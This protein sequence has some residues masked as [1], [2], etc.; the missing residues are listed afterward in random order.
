MS[1]I[2]PPLRRGFP[3]GTCMTIQTFFFSFFARADDGMT[4]FRYGKHGTTSSRQGFTTED[5]LFH[6]VVVVGSW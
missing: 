5:A 4:R 1:C 6:V 3:L 2:K